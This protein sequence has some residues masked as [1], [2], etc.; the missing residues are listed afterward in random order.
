M[1]LF[2]PRMDRESRRAGTSSRGEFRRSAGCVFR[3][4]LLVAAPP[5]ASRYDGPAV[6]FVAGPPA[7]T[8][9]VATRDA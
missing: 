2:E 9:H 7:A 4:G 3:Q 5:S 8:S 1:H 6:F